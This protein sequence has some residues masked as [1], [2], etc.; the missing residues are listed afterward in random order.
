V[1]IACRRE[2]RGWRTDS[3]IDMVCV[4][5]SKPV[6]VQLHDWSVIKRRSMPFYSERRSSTSIVS[7]KS[8]NGSF[9][10]RDLAGVIEG[11]A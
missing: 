4:P 11:P 2:R 3:V 1:V 5:L 6:H 9:T 8:E 7:E 10:N